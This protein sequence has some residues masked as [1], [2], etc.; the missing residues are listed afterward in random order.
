MVGE[1]LAEGLIGYI[2]IEVNKSASAIAATE[3][4]V[5][6]QGYLPTVSLISSAR[7]AANTLDIAECHR[8]NGMRL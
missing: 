7:A 2:T 3:E 1:T 6:V 4:D 8:T 5:N